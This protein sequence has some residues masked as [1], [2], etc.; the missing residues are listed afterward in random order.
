[1]KK[2]LFTLAIATTLLSCSSD[3]MDIPPQEENKWWFTATEQTYTRVTLS[4]GRQSISVKDSL[5]FEVS[6]INFEEVKRLKEVYTLDSY[7]YDEGTNCLPE[8]YIQV[9]GCRTWYVSKKNVLKYNA[10]K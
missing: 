8:G 5:I 2:L 6:G 3:S 9:G 1:M 4:D 10:L 7:V